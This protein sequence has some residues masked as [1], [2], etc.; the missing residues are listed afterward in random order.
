MVKKKKKLFSLASPHKSKSKQVWEQTNKLHFCKNQVQ[1]FLELL[2]TK[3]GF[4]LLSYQVVP[5]ELISMAER[6]KQYQ[7]RKEMEKDILRP[8]RKSSK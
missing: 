5:D 7:I 4:V 8:Q 2:T 1:K 6:Y 3:H